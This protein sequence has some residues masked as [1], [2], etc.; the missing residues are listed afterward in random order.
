MT[1][2]E[3]ED[4]MARLNAVSADNSILGD[5]LDLEAMSYKNLGEVYEAATGL[6]AIDCPSPQAARDGIHRFLG[7]KHDVE[8]ARG[9]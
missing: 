4:Y 6:E 9:R 1:T 3:H 7:T 5:K 8:T 2:A